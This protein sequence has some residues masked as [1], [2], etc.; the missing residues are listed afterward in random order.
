MGMPSAC[1]WH[2]ELRSSDLTKAFLLEGDTGEQQSTSGPVD[3]ARRRNGAGRG[4]VWGRHQRGVRRGEHYSVTHHV[5]VLLHFQIHQ[6][7]KG[8]CMFLVYFSLP[9][10]HFNL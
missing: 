6:I 5:S 4:A 2:P 3:R 10:S 7:S 9:L 8:C 1:F